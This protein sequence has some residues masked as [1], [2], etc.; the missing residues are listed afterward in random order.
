MRVS[1]INSTDK[2]AN[3]NGAVRDSQCLQK[4]INHSGVKELQEF[5]RVLKRMKAV[6]DG[7]S[8]FLR[9]NE[10]RIQNGIE[11][12][13]MSKD[14]EG[15]PMRLFKTVPSFGYEGV[16]GKINEKLKEFYPEQAKI[17]PKNEVVESIN[18][19]LAIA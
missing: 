6:D 1:T 17:V 5:N 2:S 3:F 4:V 19:L 12:T 18:K 14:K 9:E 15:N 16:M 11:V 10:A 13:F 7:L 8:F